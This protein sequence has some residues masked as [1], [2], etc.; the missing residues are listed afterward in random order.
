MKRLFYTYTKPD[1]INPYLIT[2]IPLV[3]LYAQNA[4]QINITNTFRLLIA[5]FVII[6]LLRFIFSK[7]RTD[8]NKSS[9]VITTAIF[10]SFAAGYIA[11]AIPYF[12]ILKTPHFVL[13]RNPL[14]MIGT[15]GMSALLAWQI[16]KTKRE[17]CV[18]HQLIAA[19]LLIVL[20][21]NVFKIGSHILWASFQN[22][23]VPLSNKVLSVA[24][25]EQLPDIYYLILDG[26]ARADVLAQLYQYPHNELTEFLQQK[27]FYVA[28]KSQPNYIYTHLSLATA[29]NYDYIENLTQNFKYGNKNPALLQEMIENSKAARR[30]KNLGYSYVLLSSGFHATEKSPLAATNYEYVY[31]LNNFEL[32]FLRS[33]IFSRFLSYINLDPRTFHRNRILFEFKTLQ[34]I[35]F[36]SRPTFTFAHILAPHPPFVFKEFGEEY[37][38]G[39]KF[40]L[41]DGY[42]SVRN[43]MEYKDGY[44]QQL[45]YIDKLV[46]STV[47]AILARSRVPPIIIIQG[48]HGPASE[49]DWEKNPSTF[50]SDIIDT[51]NPTSVYERTSILNA[52]YFPYGGNEKLY[53]TIS[54]INSF[55][56]L[57]NYYF[58]GDFP[59]LEDKTFIDR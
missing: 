33:N 48:D 46:I 23:A 49:I 12:E 53:S 47:T 7:L 51:K 37:G 18:L 3:A 58:N 32:V 52:Y 34:E 59:L 54:P 10:L 56:V 2:Y 39:G 57:F 50:L 4:S 20:F 40:T 44:L 5:I 29:L 13:S 25:I 21:I 55:R 17:L 41:A 22:N 43:R 27:E 6:S 14:L 15:V 16:I 28:S 8:S 26:H 42:G 36:D 30:L 31:D 35:P 19:T 24:G 1:I 38:K 9:L 45:K 11:R